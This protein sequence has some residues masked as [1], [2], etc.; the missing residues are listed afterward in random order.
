MRPP[1]VMNLPEANQHHHHHHLQHIHIPMR[2]VLLPPTRPL[3]D[4]AGVNE[5]LMEMRRNQEMRMR[6]WNRYMEHN[7]ANNGNSSGTS[8][9]RG[10]RD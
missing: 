4:N 3:G 1:P 5:H 8:N 7:T 6:L 9:N 10:N 2:P